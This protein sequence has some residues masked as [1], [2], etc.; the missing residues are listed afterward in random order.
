MAL[1]TYVISRRVAI[2]L[3]GGGNRPIAT[4]LEITPRSKLGMSSRGSN[5]LCIVAGPFDHS[6]LMG[7]G[8]CLLASIRNSKDRHIDNKQVR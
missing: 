2:G 3:G 1:H 8:N 5:H 4:L 7:G 6:P